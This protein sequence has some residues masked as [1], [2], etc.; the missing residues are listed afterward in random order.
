MITKNMFT[1]PSRPQLSARVTVP[2]FAVAI[3]TLLLLSGNALAEEQAKCRYGMVGK[4]A[5]KYHGA[6]MAVTAEGKINN[7]PAVMLVDTGSTHTTLT[8]FAIDKRA[9]PLEPT[10]RTFRGI[11]GTTR[12]Y[13]APIKQFQIGPIN[14][15]YGHGSMQVIDE[16]GTRP[17]YDAL[18]GSDFLMEQDIELSLADKQMKFFVPKNCEKTFLAYW[19]KGAVSVPLEFGVHFKRP[20]V[21]IALN[22][23]KMRALLD[24]GASGSIIEAAAA[25]RAGITLDSPNV[26]AGSEGTGVGKKLSRTFEATFKT[27][28]IGD[29]TIQNAN[30]RII[31]QEMEEFEV[32]LGTDFMRAHRILFAVSQKLLYLSYI[33]GEPFHSDSSNKWVEQEADA[34]NGYAQYYMATGALDSNREVVKAIGRGWMDKS[35]ANNT[36]IALHYMARQHANEARYAESIALYERMIA[37]DA[38][39]ITTQLEA[40]VVRVKAGQSDQAKTALVSAMGGF[41]WPKWPAPITD[42]YLGKLS[43]DALLREANSDRD[44]ARNRK[45]EVYNHASALQKAVGDTASSKALD[46][47][48][49]AE[50]GASKAG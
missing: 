17:D 14:T 31:D 45:C 11:G 25:R 22:G 40:Y 18:V 50:C 26:K 5:L 36:P 33:G 7:T 49:E 28:S 29:E 12:S 15:E 21:E 46:A 6:T 24:T 35:I 2:R 27:F 30:L 23:V 10:M 4:L 43:L 8:R 42:Y 3:C 16:T 47:K 44:L 41:K 34:G 48:A 39:D 13:Q 9:I 32:I 38:F 20:I 1:S 19:D 37:L